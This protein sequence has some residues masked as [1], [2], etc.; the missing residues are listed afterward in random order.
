MKTR[1]SYGAKETDYLY[2]VPSLDAYDLNVL[3]QVM[4]ETA[5]LEGATERHK[6]PTS[7]SL[8]YGGATMMAAAGFPEYI[9]AIYGGWSEGSTS[10]RIYTKPSE[11][12]LQMVSMHMS[13]M[14]LVNTSRHFIMDATARTKM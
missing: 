12:M 4:A 7:H 14:A 3:H 6:K 11:E 1:D 9:I 13:A 2:H 10:L 5:R 8:R